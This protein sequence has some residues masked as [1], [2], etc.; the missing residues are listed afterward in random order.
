MY[1][2]PIPVTTRRIFYKVK[3]GETLAAIAQKHHVSV[4]DIKRWNSVSQA[5][6]GRTLAIEVRAAKTLPKGKPRAKAKG[7]VYKKAES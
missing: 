3:A 2:P 1:A 4:E 7:K 5:V 6:A